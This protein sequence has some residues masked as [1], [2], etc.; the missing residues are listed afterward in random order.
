MK[1]KRT[2]ITIKLKTPVSTAETLQTIK[3]IEYYQHSPK[4]TERYFFL[5][6]K[7]ENCLGPS[8]YK[9]YR[10]PSHSRPVRDD[11]D[12]G[13][14]LRLQDGGGRHNEQEGEQRTRRRRRSNEVRTVDDVK[15]QRESLFY[16]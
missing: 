4:L 2:S 9:K 3:Y 14:C 5:K 10:K 1:P 12:R 8:A 15:Q 6:G 13:P 7:T 11:R 16:D